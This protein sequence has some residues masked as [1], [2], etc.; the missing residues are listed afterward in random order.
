MAR[1]RHRGQNLTGRGT[2]LQLALVTSPR[3]SADLPCSSETKHRKE[4]VA[5]IQSLSATEG[6]AIMREAPHGSIGM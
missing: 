1:P 3:H 6:G 2:D 4:A 5:N